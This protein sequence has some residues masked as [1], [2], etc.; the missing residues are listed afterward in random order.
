MAGNKRV[1][2]RKILAD[3]EL[4]RKLMV[5]TIQATQAREGIHTSEEQAQRAYYVVSEAERATFVDLTKGRGLPGGTDLRQEMFV[6]TIRGETTGVRFDI[7]RRDF[8]T[9]EGAPL[10]YR[11]L[12]VL[13]AL[14]RANTGLA[15][16]YADIKIGHQTFDDDRFVR[17]WWEIPSAERGPRRAWVPFAKGGE[18]SRFYADIYLVVRWDQ[19]AKA[20]Y[21]NR[22][23][24]FNVLLTTSSSEYLYRPGLTW[25]RAASVFNVR[26]LPPGCIFADK[27]PAIFPCDESNLW[28]LC[29]ILNS[30]LALFTL[31]GLTSREDMGGRWEAGMVKRLPIAEP[32][33]L[34]R[35][36]LSDLGKSIFNAKSE[37]DAGNETS[38]AFSEPWL[39]RA[40]G[41]DSSV[42]I[43]DRLTSLL[44]F[45]QAQNEELRAT[46]NSLNEE[47]Y[48]LYG[49]PPQ[50]RA[51]IREN[52]GKMHAEVV[53]P[54]MEGKTPDQKR[55]EHVWRLLSYAVKRVV[56]SD[57]DGVVP[58]LHV[59]GGAS[60]LDRMHAELGKL[61]P[62]RDVNEVEVEIV[63]ELKRKVK[64]YARTESV[65]EWLEDAYFE[66]HASMYRN[67]PIFW[68]IS[69]KQG[70]GPAAFAALA[71][72]QRFDKD[73][74][75]KLRGVY[76]REAIATFRRESAIASQAGRAD[77]RLEWQSKVEEAEALDRRLQQVQE[78]F[79]QGAE[80]FR[81]LTPWKIEGQR[82]K[83]WDPD[84]NDGV[85]VNIEPL[86]RAGVLRIPEVV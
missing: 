33:H 21:A 7:P 80:D 81:I 42:E 68:H 22:S 46:S 86:Q 4:R 70:K 8:G 35:Q 63:N 62:A 51:A 5:S 24:N 65:R 40:H 57:E 37:W 3:P 48:S 9:I 60:V 83:G 54:R 61:F 85:K 71:H 29:A 44:H 2:L 27:G 82:P 77:D 39:I 25:P 38:S 75:A 10:S 28:F 31:K 12:A 16:G 47:V 30:E 73:R 66:Y 34:Q 56:E 32:T 36:R 15:P 55:Q 76:L 41:P 17:F 19:D 72:Y 78:G 13:S 58:F 20:S 23:S 45:E 6:R 52:L 50:T 64:G 79:H 49:I 69:S 53:W 14:F 84:I 59:S 74:I 43:G 26:L 11:R 1:D 67:R 18:F